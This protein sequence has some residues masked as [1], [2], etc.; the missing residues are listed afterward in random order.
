MRIDVFSLFP[1]YFD[2]PWR[3][4]LLGRAREAGTVDLRVHDPRVHTDDRYRTVDDTPFGGGAGMVMMP[5]PLFAAVELV[6]P[7]RPLFLLSASGRRFDH[8][9]A[10]SGPGAR[11][12]SGAR[13]KQGR[14]TCACTTRAST[15]TTVIGPSTTRR[16]AAARAW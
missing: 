4:S 13:E 7:P 15:P 8:G 2:G 5:G 3:A 11:R 16:S 12:C 1:E 10:S 9:V 14:S 6:D